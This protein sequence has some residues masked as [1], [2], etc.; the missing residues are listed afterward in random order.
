LQQLRQD[1]SSLKDNFEAYRKDFSPQVLGNHLI[2][3]LQACIA[4]SHQGTK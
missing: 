1:Q 3:T 4:K 2:A